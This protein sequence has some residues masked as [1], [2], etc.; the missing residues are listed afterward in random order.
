[1]TS[2]RY[3]AFSNQSP[4]TSFITHG[5]QE[6]GVNAATH[7][8]THTHRVETLFYVDDGSS[9]GRR[10]IRANGAYWNFNLRCPWNCEQC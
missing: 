7:T 5:G 2:V 4:I 10:D 3:G 1:M 6:W 9:G 8:H